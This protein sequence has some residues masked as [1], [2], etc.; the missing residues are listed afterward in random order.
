M[1]CA[2]SRLKCSSC[3]R[4]LRFGSENLLDRL[5]AFGSLNGHLNEVRGGVMDL[6]VFSDYEPVQDLLHV[7][8]PRIPPCRRADCLVEYR[9]R[10]QLDS[11]FRVEQRCALSTFSFQFV[12]RRLSGDR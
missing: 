12:K 7:W 9:G 11:R 6:D 10:G 3:L 8:E 1:N 4:F 5:R 2:G